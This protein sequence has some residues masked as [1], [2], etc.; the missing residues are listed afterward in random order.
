MGRKRVRAHQNPLNTD[1]A[2]EASAPADPSAMDWSPHFP[3]FFPAAVSAAGGSAAA[4]TPQKEVTIADVGCGFG[5]LLDV[6]SPHFPDRLIV[7]LEIRPQA[8]DIVAERIAALRA[9][10]VEELAAAAAAADATTKGEKGS[11]TTAAATSTHSA[12]PP[13]FSNISVVRTN[14]MKFAA[15]YFRKG[16]LDKLFILL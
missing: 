12:P 11:A 7:G 14:I 1:V 8:V 3:H 15:N 16:Q 5:G 4:A 9:K 6:L 2:L 10:G 13:P